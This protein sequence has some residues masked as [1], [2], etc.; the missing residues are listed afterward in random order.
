MISI[1]VSPYLFLCHVL[2]SKPIKL[3]LQLRLALSSGTILYTDLRYTGVRS[4]NYGN[5]GSGQAAG[6]GRPSVSTD[7]HDGK[8]ASETR[9][10]SS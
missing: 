8:P 5:Q 2:F 1:K 6:S 10:A 7:S 9:A 3:L 4:A